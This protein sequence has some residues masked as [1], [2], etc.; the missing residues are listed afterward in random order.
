MGCRLAPRAQVGISEGAGREQ[1][2]SFCAW[3]SEKQHVLSDLCFECLWLGCF[4]FF[5][6]LFQTF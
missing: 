5:E 1:L 4:L 2:A 6:Q 3:L